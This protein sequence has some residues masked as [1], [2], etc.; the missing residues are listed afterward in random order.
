MKYVGNTYRETTEVTNLNH[1]DV[2]P[3]RLIRMEYFIFPAWACTDK[4]VT[5]NCRSA[6][7][8]HDVECYRNRRRLCNLDIAIDKETGLPVPSLVTVAAFLS[9]CTRGQGSFGTRWKLRMLYT[10]P[11]RDK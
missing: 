9:A 8:S 10:L 1:T 6:E 2:Y 3:N 11:V 5:V 7:Q 4:A